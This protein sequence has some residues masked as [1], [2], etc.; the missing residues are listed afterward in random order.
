MHRAKAIHFRLLAA[1]VFPDA[2]PPVLEIEEP[3]A[4]TEIATATSSAVVRGARDGRQG[5]VFMG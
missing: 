1:A 4:P 5:A 3:Q 2:L